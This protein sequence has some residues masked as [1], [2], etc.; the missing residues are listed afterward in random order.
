MTNI[1]LILGLAL[2]LA[3]AVYEQHLL[4]KRQPIHFAVTL[5]AQT[6]IDL[7]I[8][9]GLIALIIGQGVQTGITAFTLFLLGMSAILALYAVFWRKPQ[10]YLGTSGLFWG[11]FSLDYRRIARIDLADKQRLVF[12][13][14]NGRRLCL[15]I[16]SVEDLNKVVNFFGGYQTANTRSEQ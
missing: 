5:K 3:Y 8:L 13:L 9:I 7:W 15:A 16:Q 2:A 14:T 12:T 11:I 4:P 10:L 6:P 1:L